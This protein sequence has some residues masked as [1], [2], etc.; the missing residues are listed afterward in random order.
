MGVSKFENFSIKQNMI[1][2]YSKAL[3]HP[4]RVAILEEIIRKKKVTCG[5]LCQNLALAQSTI[6]QHLTELK[7]TGLIYGD[8]IGSKVEY[9]INQKHWYKQKSIVQL[10]FNRVK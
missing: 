9:S 10:F 7:N 5:H 3:S 6:S 1:A 8:V 2:S 4:A